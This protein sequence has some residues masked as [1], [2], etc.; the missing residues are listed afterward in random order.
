MMTR[1]KPLPFFLEQSAFAT[2]RANEF[3]VSRGRLRAS[4]LRTPFRGV[5]SE[6]LDFDDVVHRCR[7]AAVFMDEQDVFSHSTALGLWGVPLPADLDRAEAALHISTH[8]TTRRR[9]KGIVGHRLAKE[10]AV[11][12]TPDGYRAVAPATSWCQF[13]SQRDGRTDEEMLLALVSA[14]DYLITGRRAQRVREQ[15]TCTSEELHAAAAAYGPGRGARLLAQALA[16]MKSG[17]D[18]PKE[19][20]LRLL[21]VKAGL[22]AP[23]VG[24][25]IRTRIG[26]L[27]PDLTYPTKRVL[28]EYEGDLHRN[29]RRR[30]RGDFDRV[31]AFQEAGWTV[32]RVNSDDLADAARRAALTAQ[33]RTLLT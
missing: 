15:A 7:A 1:R 10:I 33:L 18:S 27:T 12:L 4:D 16:L 30:W 32:I 9:R 26:P 19:T 20:E 29:D 22:G 25:V 17:V 8:G 11:R 24:H 13:A 14:A 28:L 31:R 5:R 21:L 3:E 23:E 6:G 2:S